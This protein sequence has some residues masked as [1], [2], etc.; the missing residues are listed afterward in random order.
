LRTGDLLNP[1]F[2]PSSPLKKSVIVTPPFPI[3][4]SLFFRCATPA[5][6]L[7]IQM[8]SGSQLRCSCLI[9][10]PPCLRLGPFAPRPPSLEPES[11]RAH[12]PLAAILSAF[13][14]LS[15]DPGLPFHTHGQTAAP[16]LM[17]RAVRKNW[18]GRCACCILYF[19]C[20]YLFPPRSEYFRH[21]SSAISKSTKRRLPTK[22]DDLNPP[23]SRNRAF[24]SGL[25]YFA[26][27]V[28]PIFL[29]YPP[30]TV[31]HPCHDD[32]RFIQNYWPRTGLVGVP[33]S[34]IFVAPHHAPADIF[35]PFLSI[36]WPPF[37]ASNLR[38]LQY[39]RRI[40]A[41]KLAMDELLVVRCSPLLPPFPGFFFWGVR[42]SVSLAVPSDRAHLSFS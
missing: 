15:P 21:S 16:L 35:L 17:K 27:A 37:C 26:G 29:S 13:S 41:K 34:L 8:E 32:P 30:L 18:S 22:A 9:N 36:A 31:S 6:L 38:R 25:R 39:S 28:R 23:P 40:L 42:L 19:S 11:D 33:P 2:D 20:H 14:S 10:K 5:V 24:R 4:P 12:F 7:L 1:S 3:Y